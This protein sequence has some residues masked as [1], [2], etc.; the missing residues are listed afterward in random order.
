M[1]KISV[2]KKGTI[3]K[4]AWCFG[5]FYR[6]QL[7]PPPLYVCTA[8]KNSM[9]QDYG[10]RVARGDGV[11]APKK[12]TKKKGKERKKERRK[13]KERREREK[14]RKHKKKSLH[15]ISWSTHG[16]YSS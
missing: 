16:M 4:S 5:Q 14:I 7:P 13:K 2:K 8:M 10:R 15:K 11:V 3:Q 12:V 1:G 6:G 9:W